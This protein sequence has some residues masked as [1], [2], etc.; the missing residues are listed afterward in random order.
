[1][2]CRGVRVRHVPEVSGGKIMVGLQVGLKPGIK[3]GGRYDEMA[4][5]SC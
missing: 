1:M 4:T 3:T 5:V 2:V